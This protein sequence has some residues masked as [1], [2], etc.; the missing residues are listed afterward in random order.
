MALNLS[1]HEFCDWNSNE[2]ELSDM[3]SLWHSQ[4]AHFPK[5]E[6]PKL[7]HPNIP[8]QKMIVPQH[9]VPQTDY[10]DR[11]LI[12]RNQCIPRMHPPNKRT[13]SQTPWFWNQG[14]LFTLEP[15]SP[16]LTSHH[17]QHHG[18]SFYQRHVAS[19]W[20]A[21]AATNPTIAAPLRWSSA[22]GS[23]GDS[24]WPM[25]WCIRTPFLW[26]IGKTSI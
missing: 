12:T 19:F 14:S 3:P 23:C 6:C 5:S 2:L 21:F 20:A 13:E 15:S 1:D 9:P 24:P 17:G 10:I 22:I 16:N 26:E 18:R 7:G 4:K 11:Q 25:H 8:S